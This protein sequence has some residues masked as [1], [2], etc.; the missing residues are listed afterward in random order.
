M[1]DDDGRTGG[2]LQYSSPEVRQ[3]LCDDGKGNGIRGSPS[4]Q[5]GR[6]NG[7]NRLFSEV[8]TKAFLG[9]SLMVGHTAQ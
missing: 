9:L 4:S 2:Q 3:V 6:G 5:D 1:G 8:S 7:M